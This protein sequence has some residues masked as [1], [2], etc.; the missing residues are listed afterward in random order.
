[1]KKGCHILFSQNNCIICQW[2]GYTH[3]GTVINVKFT[4]EGDMYILGQFNQTQSIILDSQ[5]NFSIFEIGENM[6]SLWANVN[7]DVPMY[8]MELCKEHDLKCVKVS[9]IKTAIAG[10]KFT[11]IIAIDRFDIEI[12]YLYRKGKDIVKHPCGSFFAQAYD[13]KDR[14]NLLSGEGADIYI[15]NCLLITARGLNSKWKN[16]LEGDTKW[17]EKYK[18]SSRYAIEKLTNDEIEVVSECLI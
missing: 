7:D 2:S 11:I 6:D 9:P 3:P 1:M 16:V 17:L 8:M 18:S 15:R 10:D 5:G 12:Y 4:S 13:S 14:E